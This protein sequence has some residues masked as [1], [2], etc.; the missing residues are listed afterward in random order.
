M[1]RKIVAGSAKDLGI[2]VGL[3]YADPL[4]VSGTDSSFA[5]GTPGV[6][7]RVAGIEGASIKTNARL[8]N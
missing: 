8:R 5:F 6:R 4:T 7:V 2:Q 1:L 3:S